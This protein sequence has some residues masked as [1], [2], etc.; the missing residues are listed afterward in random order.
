MNPA[1]I[2]LGRLYT[3]LCHLWPFVSDPQEYA[4]EAGHWQTI[5]RE[6]L[7]EGRHRLLELG[8]GGG[9]NLSHFAAD[10][11]VIA[12]DL[13][14]R[15][16]E[17]AKALNPSVKFLIG[18]MRSVR[19]GEKF[20]AILIHDA[21][22]HMLTESDLRATLLTVADHLKQGG[23]AIFS[24]DHFKETFA[25][26]SHIF[27]SSRA[28]ESTRVTCLEYHYDLD[29]NDTTTECI[30]M[31]LIHDSG[32]LKIEFDRHLLGLFPQ[33][34]WIA[35]MSDAGFAPEVRNHRLGPERADYTLLVGVRR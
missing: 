1:D 3:D 25:I 14:E 15:M 21:I 30:M 6:K 27:S 19:L 33:A 29:P 11:D 20:D 26:Q 12:V 13:S 32:E 17:H 7:G 31:F 4:E 2:P 22:S 18:D 16:I 23:V 28:I 8:V 24:P 10:H 34:T 9:H 5:L 35:M